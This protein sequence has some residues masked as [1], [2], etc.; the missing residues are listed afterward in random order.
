MVKG[1]KMGFIIV[2]F[3]IM[4]Y[5]CHE[6]LDLSIL[7]TLFITLS[8]SSIVWSFI[9]IDNVKKSK[10][11]IKKTKKY[12]A[13]VVSIETI[14]GYKGRTTYTFEL[15]IEDQII[16]LTKDNIHRHLEM[17]QKLDVYPIYDEQ[18]NIIDFDFVED[19]EINSKVFIPIIILAIG[20]TISSVM[21]ILIDKAIFMT[22]LS[23]VI[24][25]I[26]LLLLCIPVAI[27]SI[28]RAM[29]NKNELIPVKAIIHSLRIAYRNNEHGPD[30]E[31]ISPIYRVEVD[32]KTYQFVGDKSAK[33]ED[34]GKECVVYYDKETMEFFDKP[35][36]KVDLIMGVIM[37]I[38]IIVIVNNLF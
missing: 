8:I 21:F 22:V 17:N 27:I 5:V 23:N 13:K 20:T 30:S 18:K 33:R 31:S 29:I 28:K 26:F 14:H 4:Y 19:V 2:L 1:D 36:S 34:K 35:K 32:G 15:K 7:T 10:E 9:D 12:I 38:F 11:K 3:I 37:I 6:W 16:R 24:V 25:S